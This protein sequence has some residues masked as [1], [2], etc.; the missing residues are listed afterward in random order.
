RNTL[1]PLAS[2]DLL[3]C[4]RQR[5]QFWFTIH[6]DGNQHIRFRVFCANP[7]E[8]PSPSFGSRSIRYPFRFKEIRGREIDLLFFG[9]TFRYLQ[10][11]LQR[12]RWHGVPS[13]K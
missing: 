4:A 7:P 13:W 6:R 9:E 8:M 10:R 11:S 12:K 5:K 2:N 3:C 1:P